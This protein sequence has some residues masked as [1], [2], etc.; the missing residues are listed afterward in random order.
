MKSELQLAT[1]QF[2]ENDFDDIDKTE[3]LLINYK[4]LYEKAKNEFFKICTIC[5]EISSY[6]SFCDCKIE[7]EI[8]CNGF[9]EITVTENK[10]DCK[11]NA[12]YRSDLIYFINIYNG[13]ESNTLR[14][15][16]KNSFRA[17]I[18]SIDYEIHKQYNGK[19]LI[20]FDAKL[21][22]GPVKGEVVKAK[23]VLLKSLDFIKRNIKVGD[24]VFLNHRM[25]FSKT[26]PNQYI[27]YF[28]INPNDI[29]DK[30]DLKIF[31]NVF[32]SPITLNDV[33][34]HLPESK[35][36]ENTISKKIAFLPDIISPT[37]LYLSLASL[38]YSIPVLLLF[39]FK[40]DEISFLCTFFIPVYFFIY[41][42]WYDNGQKKLKI[43]FF[44]QL[45]LSEKSWRIHFYI[46]IGLLAIHLILLIVVLLIFG[47]LIYT[48]LYWNYIKTKISEIIDRIWSKL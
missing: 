18:N 21:D 32:N 8:L 5:Y 9:E 48:I 37:L 44:N 17:Y 23:L 28:D 19:N 10:F 13:T 35:N 34:E 43:E 40:F 45:L 1:N 16:I 24:L 42:S 2:K 38:L 36:I 11:D 14:I 31:E 4:E 41:K 12:F 25:S 26:E 47:L 22:S 39:D 27:H 7:G 15:P 20:F 3:Q 30:N 29:M 46:A 6:D 33:T